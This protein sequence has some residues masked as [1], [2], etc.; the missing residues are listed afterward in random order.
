MCHL[1]C[2]VIWRFTLFGGLFGVVWG[3]GG[4]GVGGGVVGGGWGGGGGRGE[5]HNLMDKKRTVNAVDMQSV[6]YETPPTAL[7]LLRSE[8]LFYF[9][10]ILYTNQLTRPWLYFQPENKT[11]SEPRHHIL[12]LNLWYHRMNLIQASRVRDFHCVDKPLA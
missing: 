1:T 8:W 9:K 11:C 12:L 5:L 4:G 2:L 7:K 10:K 6:N 3:G